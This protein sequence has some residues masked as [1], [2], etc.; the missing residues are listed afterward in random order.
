MRFE[1][2]R[3][4]ALLSLNVCHFLRNVSQTRADFGMRKWVCLG[5]RIPASVTPGGRAVGIIGQVEVVGVSDTFC[6]YG[7]LMC[8]CP[9]FSPR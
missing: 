6:I 8:S 3:I 2:E 7:W 4:P 9:C 1:W 5:S